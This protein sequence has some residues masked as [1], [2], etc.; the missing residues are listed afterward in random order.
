MTKRKSSRLSLGAYVKRR[1]GVAM[2][3]PG[4]LQNMLERSFTATSFDRFWQYWNPIFS[5]YLGKYVFAPL[6]RVMPSAPALVLTFVFCGALHD[7]VTA[8]ARWDAAFMFTPWF[9]FMG[10]IVALSKAFDWQYAGVPVIGRAVINTS[11]I[12]ACL[13]LAFLVGF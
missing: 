6:K 8:L 3:A 5:Y 2:S 7:V 4:S 9:F 10:I 11:L 12:A 13:Y 1:N